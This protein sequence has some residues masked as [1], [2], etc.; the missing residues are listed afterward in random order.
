MIEAAKERVIAE[1]LGGAAERP[2]D[3][4]D[5]LA[6]ARELQPSTL[7]W[8]RTARNLVKYA[9]DGS[10]REVEAYLKQVKLL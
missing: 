2:I 7:D 9:G 5:L 8:L 4:P 10:Y 1:I 3:E 6:A